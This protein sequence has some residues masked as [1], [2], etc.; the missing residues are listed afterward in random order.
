MSDAIPKLKLT[1]LLLGLAGALF[2]A[3]LVLAVGTLIILGTRTD[4]YLNLEQSMER[5]IGG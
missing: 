5:F 2:V 3:V 4:A 1:R